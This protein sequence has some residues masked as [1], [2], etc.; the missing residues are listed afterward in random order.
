MEERELI[1]GCVN[2][3]KVYQRALYERYSGL[4]FSVC[5]RYSKHRAEAQDMMQDGFIK[6]FDN[7]SKFSFNGSFEGWIRRIM[8]NTCLNYYRKIGAQLEKIGVEDYQVG[9]TEPLAESNMGEKDLMAI[10]QQLPEGYRIVFNLYAI[11]GYS[12]KEIGKELGITESTSRSQLSKARKWLQNVLMKNN[13]E[14]NV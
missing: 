2:E 10:I 3:D 8:V 5:L 12:H 1:K 4:M 7:I 6:V 9:S 14:T 13:Q 11:E